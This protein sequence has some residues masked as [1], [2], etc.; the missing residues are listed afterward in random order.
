MQGSF[1]N[2][3]VV[4]DLKRQL[5][6]PQSESIVHGVNQRNG[7][8][9]QGPM[10]P[11]AL[12]KQE[13]CWQNQLSGTPSTWRW[14]QPLDNGFFV[15]DDAQRGIFES[16]VG[17]LS[18]H[19]KECRS[20]NYEACSGIGMGLV[21]NRNPNGTTPK[22]ETPSFEEYHSPPSKRAKTQ[23]TQSGTITS[24]LTFM[25]IGMTSQGFLTVCQRVKTSAIAEST[26]KSCD[27]KPEVQMSTYP[28]WPEVRIAQCREEKLPEP[29]VK[30]EATEKSIAV[31]DNTVQPQMSGVS[32][33]ESFTPE[34]IKAHI[35]SLRSSS[36]QCKEGMKRYQGTEH[37]S[38]ENLCSLCEKEQIN[39]MPTPNNKFCASCLNHINPLVVYY[40]TGSAAVS[41]DD[42]TEDKFICR[43]CFSVQNKNIRIDGRDIPKSSLQKKQA[44]GGE[45]ATCEPWVQCAR[46]KAWQ[47]QICS[48]FNETRNQSELTEY[49]C[50]TCILHG[51]ENGEKLLNQTKAYGA[52]DLPTTRLSD[53]IEKWLSQSLKKERQ[54]RAQSLGKSYEEVPGAED[55]YV[56]VVSSISKIVEVKQFF[57]ET[58]QEENHQSGFPYKSRVI[59]LFQKIEGVDVIIFA[60]YVQ[61]YGTKCPLPNQRHVCLSYL[62]SVKYF[63]PEIKTV[64]DEALRTFVYHELLLGY[65]DY[66]KKSGFTSCYIWVSP[67]K[68]GDNYILYCHP[69]TQKTPEAKKLRDWYLKVIHKA[70]QAKIAVGHSNFS[71]GFLDEKCRTNITATRLPYFDQDYWSE[72]AEEILKNTQKMSMVINSHNPSMTL[73]SAAHDTN[74]EMTREQKDAYLINELKV[75]MRPKDNF[76]MIH[77]QHCCKSC[78]KPILSGKLWISNLRKT[79]QICERCYDNLKNL[80]KQNIHSTGKEVEH[81]FY[82]VEVEKVSSFLNDE[83]KTL[84]C[85]IFSTREG[86]LNYCLQNHYEFGTL[87]RAKHSSMM[88]LYNLHTAKCNTCSNTIEPALGWQ[89]MTCSGF[90]IC[91]SCYQKDGCSSHD[92]QLVPRAN[93]TSFFSHSKETQSK[94][95]WQS[96]VRDLELAL[97]CSET[98]CSHAHCRQFRELFSH[99]NDCRIR[100]NG[101]CVNC[102]RAQFVMVVHAKYCKDGN[103]RAPSC[104]KM[105]AYLR[106]QNKRKLQEAKDVCVD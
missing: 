77:L 44:Y 93:A 56:R 71:D 8:S 86:F 46:C 96:V 36:D 48:L 88:I 100:V 84:S 67:P 37:E 106:E 5:G 23:S 12:T 33:I 104:S 105:K 27:S 97:K 57:R 68:R 89:C 65:L 29:D 92:H 79:F 91:D 30:C 21:A 78:C 32:L 82:M 3:P 26:A 10:L 72:Q 47:H 73:R 49:L 98:K 20:H 18:D 52:K 80:N 39:F 55:L 25:D 14:N 31:S 16:N 9:S 28:I 50:P 17:S 70:E 90:H 58:F 38:N 87:R 60:M 2:V 85:Q 6:W 1:F 51:S 45:G 41:K 54:E 83:D 4:V 99:T 94:L 62:D 66:C 19:S 22:I 42:L 101:G 13:V 76:I 35:A 34:Q 75:K 53:H 102:K 63:R 11:L 103:C 40:S 95:Y 43:K 81:E 15:R 61:E 69:E 64:K 59:L 74:Q 24:P 7:L